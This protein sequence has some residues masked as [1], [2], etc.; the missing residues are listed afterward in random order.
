MYTQ[1]QSDEK[2]YLLAKWQFSYIMLLGL[3]TKK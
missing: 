3:D 2:Q 1:T